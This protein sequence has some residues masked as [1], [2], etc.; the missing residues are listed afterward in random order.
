[1]VYAY[2]K[3][4][5]IWFTNILL[6]IFMYMLSDILSCNL[7]FTVSLSGLCIRQILI[8]EFWKLCLLVFQGQ[9]CLGTS[10]PCVDLCAW[11][12][13]WWD[14]SNWSRHG[15]RWDS[16]SRCGLTCPWM[17]CVLGPPGRMAG[18]GAR[19]GVLNVPHTEVTLVG[20]LELGR[21]MP[22][23]LRFLRL[24]YTQITLVGWLQLEWVWA[25]DIPVCI[26]LGQTWQDR[27]GWYG[28]G[29]GAALVGRLGYLDPTFICTIKWRRN[30]NRVFLGAREFQQF[31]FCLADSL[32]LVNRFPSLIV[33][34]S[35]KLVCFCCTPGQASLHTGPFTM[36]LPTAGHCV[37]VEVPVTTVSPSVLFSVC[38]LCHWLCSYVSPQFFFWRNFSLYIEVDFIYRGR[39]DVSMGESEFKV[40]ICCHLGLPS[41]H[42]YF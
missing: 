18:A 25:Q 6:M 21:H 27:W 4:C 36:S 30:E 26:M 31:P 24:C 39:L 23:G 42:Q 33:K 1:M 37:R 19:V 17:C 22:G 13:L 11:E 32:G 40:F 35:F 41:V 29:P 2:F 15:P 38:L 16:W 28:S 5:G 10:V 12:L 3:I 9:D 20:Q 7:L 34:L 14:G 8:K